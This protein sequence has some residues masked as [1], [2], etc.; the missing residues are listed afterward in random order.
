M[1][2]RML[3]VIRLLKIL[4]VLNVLTVTYGRFRYVPNVHNSSDPFS[5]IDYEW[6]VFTNPI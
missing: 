4:K 5:A 1:K 2:L 6:D 3:R